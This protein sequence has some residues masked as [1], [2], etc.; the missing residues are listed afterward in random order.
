M[1][2]KPKR[3]PLEQARLD[4]MRR[5][6]RHVAILLPLPCCYCGC[7]LF[8]I[9]SHPPTKIKNP[10]IPYNKVC[11][12]RTSRSCSNHPNG[13]SHTLPRSRR[14]RKDSRPPARV[15]SP[16]FG[17]TRRVLR[18]VGREPCNSARGGGYACERVHDQCCRCR[19][20]PVS[21]ALANDHHPR[22]CRSEQRPVIIHQT[23]E[24][25]IIYQQLI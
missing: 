17:S 16:L 12:S 21:H 25:N 13:K 18:L 20:Q 2:S 22:S 9:D 23:R 4:V 5:S 19:V 8:L 7:F 3:R 1:P 14:Y 24:D 10:N 6:P 15:R 11:A